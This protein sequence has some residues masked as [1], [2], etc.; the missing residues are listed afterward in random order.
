VKL[1]ALGAVAVWSL[2][3][4]GA[5]DSGVVWDRFVDARVAYT[6]RLPPGWH[7]TALH[8]ATI[9]TSVPVANRYGNPERVRLPRGG[10]YV[11][12]FD[13]G[14]MPGDFPE[15]PDRL[16]LGRK[17]FHTCGFGEGYALHFRDRGR[18]LHVFVKLGPSTGERDAHGVL[19][20]L[21]V[22]K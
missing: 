4:P 11:W 10:V 7:A 16:H 19:N 3:A 13:Y 22:T 17:E 20:S 21:S 15:R 18:V 5:P 6:L 14:R 9:I 12:I 2:A 8:G 1:L